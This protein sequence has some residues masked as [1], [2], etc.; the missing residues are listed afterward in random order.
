MT[1][2]RSKEIHYTPQI[3]K[4]I[5]DLVAMGKSGIEI[6]KMKGMP[7]KT[8]LVR[9]RQQY[10]DFGEKWFL[11]WQRAAMEVEEEIKEIA[12]DDSRDYRM[13]EVDGKATLVIDKDNIARAKLRCY[14][15]EKSSAA[16]MPRVFGNRVDINVKDETMTAEE[17]EK[18]LIMISNKAK[19]LG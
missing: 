5:I 17:I 18:R 8:T 14:V 7:A 16:R 6:S 4:E 12:D 2:K 19:L 11:A 9:W 3:V 1:A 13:V 15:R 10:R